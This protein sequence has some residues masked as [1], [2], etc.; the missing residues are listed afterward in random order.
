MIFAPVDDLLGGGGNPTPTPDTTNPNPT[1]IP[2]PQD[3]KWQDNWKDGLDEELKKEPSLASIKDIPSLVKSYI[4]GQKMIGKEKIV[5]PD[6]FAT[7]EDWQRVYSK[8][9]MPESPDKY[10]IKNIGE[11]TDENFVKKFKEVAVKNGI[12]PRQAEKI[13]EMYTGYA[14]ELVAAQ[15]EEGKRNFEES[16][17]ALKKEWGQ[18]YDRKL[19]NASATFS[20]FADDE[21]KAVFKESGIGNN[22]KVLKL[23]ASIA[24]ALGEDKFIAPGGDG[25]LG[26]TPTEAANKIN[27]IMGNKDHAYYH[28]S[29]PMHKAAVD[30]VYRLTQAKLNSQK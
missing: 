30:E 8:L 17:G 5:I 2:A 15:E 29:H 13:F 16:V 9:G 14:N 21:T 27:E 3:F 6:Q 4:H 11:H 18:G 12:L 1:P 20:K 26:I 25:K 7:D 10:E 19:A 23:F 24:E 28:K 22:P